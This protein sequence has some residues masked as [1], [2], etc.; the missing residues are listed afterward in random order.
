VALRI[1]VALLILAVP[2]ELPGCGPFLPEALFYLKGMPEAPS[3]FALGQLGIVQPSYERLY[4]VIAY[5][6]L[7][8][9]GLNAAEQQAVLPPP[10]EPPSN[11]PVPTVTPNPWL[12]A[13]NRVPGIAPLEEIDA[14]RQVKKQGYFDSYL[15][16]N[17]DAFR[18]AAS[19]LTRLQGAPAL[20]DWIAAQDSVFANCSNGNAVPPPASDPQLRADRAYQVASAEFYSEQYDAA[21][22]DFQTI[23]GDNSSPWHGIAPYL[24]ARCLIRAGKFAE[25]ETALQKVAA[26]PAQQRWHAAASGLLGY[27]AMRLHPQQRMHELGL[28]LVKPDSQATI[29]QDLIDYRTLFDQNVRTD[30]HDDLTDWLV[31][32]QSAGRGALENWRARHT[33]PWLVAA[34]QFAGPKDSDLSEL[35]TAAAAVPSNSP[36]YLTV[37]HE[38]IRLMPPDEARPLAEQLLSGTLPLAGQNEIRSQ[39]MALAR[40][41]DEFLRFAAR[42]PVAEMTWELQAPDSKD[43]FLD[44]DSVDILNLHLPLADLKKAQTSS[45]LPAH[46][47]AELEDVIFVRTQMLSD[48]PSFDNVF[49][50]LHSPGMQLNLQVGFGRNTKEVGTIDNYRDNW[51]CSADLAD[52]PYALEKSAKPSSE[53]L[54]FLSDAEQKEA[55]DESLKFRA[56]GAA[57]DWLGAQTVAFAEKHPQDPR[58]PEALSLAVRASRYG[59]TDD[60]TGQFS[61]AAFDLLHQR[62]P[63]S[64]WA[65][66]TPFWYK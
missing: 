9:I 19:T 37:A 45:A 22:Q 60:K 18:T 53:A 14:F 26:D 57:P 64:D 21:R 52:T 62:Y 39:R 13:R 11:Q 61:K 36:G 42:R 40:N 58:L 15:N 51:W 30:Q 25:A 29:K 32:Y 43:E 46:V 3:D 27:V 66:K 28:A 38:R 54:S 7:S 49:K 35:L 12:E 41:F 50:I 10:P 23:A 5:R 20:K 34:L 6:Y 56:A 44:Q 24:A 55:A 33:L 8:G 47:R 63:N 59:C 4:K 31:S 65:K 17:E 16:C 1:L 2:L 48:A